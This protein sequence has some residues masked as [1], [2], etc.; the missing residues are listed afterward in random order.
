MT[1]CFFLNNRADHIVSGYEYRYS[2]TEPHQA[3]KLEP[4]SDEE[5]DTQE[6]PGAHTAAL[7]CCAFF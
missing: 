4:E 3:L 1:L 2:D 7:Q 6:E 5:K